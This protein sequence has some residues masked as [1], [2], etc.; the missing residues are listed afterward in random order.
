MM[1]AEFNRA[2]AA[3]TGEACHTIRRFDFSLCEPDARPGF[4][5]DQPGNRRNDLRR[6][7]SGGTTP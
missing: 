4:T 5:R 3:V 2:A 6:L 1:Q 7:A